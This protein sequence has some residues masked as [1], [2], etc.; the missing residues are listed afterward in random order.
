MPHKP[1]RIAHRAA[2]FLGVLFVLILPHPIILLLAL[3]PASSQSHLHVEGR[4]AAVRKSLHLPPP[5]SRSKLPPLSLPISS[6]FDLKRKRAL[7]ESAPRAFSFADVDAPYQL[8]FAAD[9]KFMDEEYARELNKFGAKGSHRTS[10]NESSG[11][12]TVAAADD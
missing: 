7:E 2:I 10:K 12:H 5:E 6:R 3:S 4:W 11:P 1:H 9:T 8:Y